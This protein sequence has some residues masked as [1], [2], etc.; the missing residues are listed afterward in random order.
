MGGR[1]K[2]FSVGAHWEHLRGGSEGNET[3]VYQW[4]GPCIQFSALKGHL[5][6]RFS[7]GPDVLKGNDSFYKLTFGYNF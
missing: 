2:F 4:I 6:S 3:D 1:R 7:A 5:F